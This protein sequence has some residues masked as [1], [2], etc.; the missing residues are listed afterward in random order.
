MKRWSVRRWRV[1]LA[2]D[3]AVA[4]VGV[5]EVAAWHEWWVAAPTVLFGGFAAWV[6]ARAIRLT[7]W[8]E[9]QRGGGE[10]R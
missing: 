3:L 10:D 7:R 4:G 2:V 9:A 5:F 6:A 8:L 1:A